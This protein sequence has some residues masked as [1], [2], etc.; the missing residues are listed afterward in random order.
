M[1]KWFQFFCIQN[2]SSH[3]LGFNQNVLPNAPWKGFDHHEK[4]SCFEFEDCGERHLVCCPCVIFIII[5]AFCIDVAVFL[6]NLL[7]IGYFV[8]S[9][10]TFFEIQDGGSRHLAFDFHSDFKN[11]QSNEFSM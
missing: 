8:E 6:P 2:V 3:H 4:A 11:A 7:K 9:W 10:H 1:I 5:D